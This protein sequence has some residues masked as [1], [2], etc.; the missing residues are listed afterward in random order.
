MRKYC[1]SKSASDLTFCASK[2]VMS[3]LKFAVFFVC[4]GWSAAALAAGPLVWQSPSQTNSAR[5]D[6]V[7]THFIYQ[8]RNASSN[9]V[10]IEDVKPSC[11]CTVAQLPNK[12]WR[13]RAEGETSQ[14]EALV[15]LRGKHGQLFKQIDVLSSTA[16]TTLH[17][18]VDIEPGTN[19]LPPQMQNRIWGQ[20]LAATDRQAV[21]KKDCV[22]CHLTPAFG[23]SGEP[24]FHTTCG[25]CH[26][27][28]HRATM[29]PDLHALKTEIGTNYWREWITNGKPG[30]LMPAF[31]ATQGGPLDDAQIDSLVDYLTQAYPRPIKKSTA[32]ASSGQAHE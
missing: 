14:F 5:A 1:S 7:T 26:E 15:D 25:I 31:T 16:P 12:P 32:T 21:F 11:G 18:Q 17:L 2:F 28:A 6:D 4:A 13:H 23:K 22:K 27:A 8:V 10:I 19:T 9:E 3:F 20:Q 29:V 24:L 30:T